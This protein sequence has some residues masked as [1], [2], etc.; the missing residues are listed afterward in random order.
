ML[1]PDL[2]PWRWKAFGTVWGPAVT[3]GFHCRRRVHGIA[4]RAFVVLMWHAAAGARHDGTTLH[5]RRQEAARLAAVKE[6][7]ACEAGWRV[8][9][10]PTMVLPLLWRRE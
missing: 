2:P 10:Q 6:R 8:M 9:K 1:P 7:V 5:M 4:Q 3:S